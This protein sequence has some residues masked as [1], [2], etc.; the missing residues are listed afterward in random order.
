MVSLGLILE[1]SSNFILALIGTSKFR[2]GSKRVGAAGSPI[3]R[4]EPNGPVSF[5]AKA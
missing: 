4:P 5:E 3:S 1:C 2:Y